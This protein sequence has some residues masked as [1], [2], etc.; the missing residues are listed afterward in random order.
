[1]KDLW[2]VVKFNFAFKKELFFNGS[3]DN[4]LSSQRNRNLPVPYIIFSIKNTE[5][6][7][8]FGNKRLEC[9]LI[10]SQTASRIFD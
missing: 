6:N 1:M 2:G 4:K 10:S 8:S 9:D 7:F 5:N 3:V